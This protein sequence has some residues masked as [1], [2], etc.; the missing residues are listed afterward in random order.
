MKTIT[1]IGDATG[2]MRMAGWTTNAAGESVYVVSSGETLW[3]IAQKWLGSGSRYMEIWNLQPASWRNDSRHKGSPNNLF[4]GDTLIM[5]AA[6]KSAAT[7]LGIVKAGL[8]LPGAPVL[9]AT[10]A[11]APEVVAAKSFLDTVTAAAPAAAATPAPATY[12]PAASPSPASAASAP[13]TVRESTVIEITPLDWAKANPGKAAAIGVGV[14]G[15]GA[16]LGFA[17]KGDGRRR[18]AT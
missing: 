12:V 4:A 7:Q 17:L 8:G 3:S 10:W 6:A 18:A 9:P 1:L 5:P 13:V 2:G 14:I 16:L 15:A 11:S